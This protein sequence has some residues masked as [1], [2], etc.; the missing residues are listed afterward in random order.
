[1]ISGNS[2]AL[3]EGKLGGRVEGGDGEVE[4]VEQAQRLLDRARHLRQ[5]LL[6]RVLRALPSGPRCLDAIPCGGGR[7]GRIRGDVL[8]GAAG[9]QKRKM[10][11]RSRTERK[12]ATPTGPGHCRRFSRG[13]K[14]NR[15]EKLSF[16]S[17]STFY[18]RKILETESRS[19]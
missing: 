12:R 18:H 10:K 15:T 17:V 3:E 11:E 4:L 9:G 13:M 16:I 14:T 6:R 1:V 8:H 2:Q 7:S 19:K 5:V